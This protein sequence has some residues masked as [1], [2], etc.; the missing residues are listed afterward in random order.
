MI[1]STYIELA[2]FL[3]RT[4]GTI[5]FLHF[6][7]FASVVLVAKSFVVHDEVVFPPLG[8]AAV[9]LILVNILEDAFD[10]LDLTQN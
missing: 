8:L 3:L 4:V 2:L 9:V 7:D 6:P 1:F 5:A 10:F